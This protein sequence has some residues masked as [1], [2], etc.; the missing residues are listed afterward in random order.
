MGDQNRAIQSATTINAA[1]GSVVDPNIQFVNSP[2]YQTPGDKEFGTFELG[3]RNV[4]PKSLF[5]E[6]VSASNPYT[7][8]FAYY[9]L[10]KSGGAV[11][12]HRSESTDGAA[13]ITPAVS[14]NPTAANIISEVSKP[15][16]SKNFPAYMDFSG[17]SP[18]AGQPYNVKDFIF[19]K[20]YGVI[21]NN[22]MITLRR[23]PGPVLDSLRVPTDSSDIKIDGKDVSV[24]GKAKDNIQKILEDGGETNV[25]LPVAQAVTYFGEGTGNA[26]SDILKFSTGLNFNPERQSEMLN[27]KTGDP[28]LFNTPFGDILKSALS[29]SASE[30]AGDIDKI[31]GTLQNPERNINKLRR[32]FL[33][34]ET[35]AGGPLSKKIFVNLNTVDSMMVRQRGFNGGFETFYLVFDYNLTSA[36]QINSKMLF[37][38]L[39]ANILSLGSDYGTFLSPEVR[40]DQQNVGIGFP[41]GGEG[42]AKLLTNPLEYIKGAVNGVL[43]ENTVNKIKELEGYTKEAAEDL[44]RFI[45]DPSKGIDPNSKFMKSLSVFISDIFLKQV[46]FKPI[47][48]S[49]YPTGDWHMVVGNPLNPIAMIGNLVCTSVKIDFDET[50]GPD[51]F[52][53]GF[54]ATFSMQHGRQRHKGDFESHL[55]RGNGR[56]YLGHLNTSE[57]SL[58]AFQDTTGKSLAQ[59]V[60]EGQSGNGSLTVAANN[61]APN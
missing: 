51:D 29:P 9:V 6:A 40:L 32:Y 26:L 38:D 18:Y 21:P 33:D 2:T 43:N 59:I 50:L 17:K 41:G 11:K 55:N 8:L 30:A 10:G 60:A 58:K 52:P 12:Y 27:M 24:N 7:G 35:T 16:G 31:L 39:I 44:K 20:H 49:G 47:M 5:Y 48:L 56:L 22:R 19:C 13:V 4:L 36:G 15:S 37:L 57:E 45:N 3:Q 53:I 42:Y 25:N 28:G 1:S 34:L 14:R 23:F 54:K 61:V 46:Y